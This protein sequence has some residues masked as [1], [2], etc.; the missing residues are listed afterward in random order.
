MAL[1]TLLPVK[2]HE[3]QL[4][5]KR[6]HKESFCRHLEA[7]PPN[8][9]QKQISKSVLQNSRK[10]RTENGQIQIMCLQLSKLTSNPVKIYYC[11]FQVGF[12][13]FSV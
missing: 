4:C 6:G 3:C 11:Y 7:K 12:N 5:H 2:N 9:I 10:N 13:P 8:Q 1:H